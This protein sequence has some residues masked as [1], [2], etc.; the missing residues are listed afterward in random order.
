MQI[1]TQQKVIPPCQ[2]FPGEAGAHSSAV[3]F[4][5]LPLE[6]QQPPLGIIVLQKLSHIKY[7][8]SPPWYVCLLSRL[9]ALSLF[10][11]TPTY[12]RYINFLH[13]SCQSMRQFTT[14]PPPYTVEVLLMNGSEV[15]A[16][17]FLFTSI[18]SCS[19]FPWSHPQQLHSYGCVVSRVVEFIREKVED[20][21]NPG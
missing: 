13:L 7:P 14:A 17:P 11:P 16:A 19:I 20:V 6:V 21:A 15:V 5:S 10:H 12:P 4:L 8:N 1:H 2:K 18:I 3:N 9:R